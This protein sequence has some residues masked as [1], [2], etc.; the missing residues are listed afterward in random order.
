MTLPSLRF[1][2]AKRLRNALLIV[3]A[4]SLIS[5]ILLPVYTDE[6]GWRLQERA[7]LD[8]L[9][10]LYSDICGPNTLAVPPWFMW[11]VRYYSAF[12]N[13]SFPDP[14]FIRLSGIGYALVWAVLLLALTKA[15]AE[16]IER[17]LSLQMIAFGLMTMGVMP[18]LL[19]W[20]RPEQ[21]ILLCLTAAL[22]VQATAK[23]PSRDSLASASLRAAGILTLCIIALSYHLKAVVLA[24]IFVVCVLSV[25]SGR[26]TMLPRVIAATAALAAAAVSFRYWTERL[27]CPDD[28]ASAALFAENN[29]GFQGLTNG[30]FLN[31]AIMMVK[32]IDILQFALRI[33]PEVVPTSIWIPSMVVHQNESIAFALIHFLSWLIALGIFLFYLL[34]GL[35]Q[36]LQWRAEAVRFILAVMLVGA[37]LAW[38]APLLI[39]NPYEAIFVLPTIMLGMLFGFSRGSGPRLNSFLNAYARGIAVVGMVSC[40]ASWVFYGP[41]LAKSAEQSGYLQR[42]P[43]SVAPFNYSVTRDQIRSAAALCR[44]ENPREQTRILIDDVTYFSF[45]ESRMPDHQIGVIGSWK[46]GIDDPLAYL[47]SRNSSGIFVGCHLLPPDIRAKAKR[48]GAI[49]C[50]NLR[51]STN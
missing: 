28:P 16:K 20:S 3:F 46:G 27:K 1:F 48:H 49:C 50:L 13:T 5:G 40:L 10:K 47:R 44:M 32:N 42:Q 45:M 11:P 26:R 19:V 25:A 51:D 30:N 24:P 17:R 22:L 31:T 39:V 4:A 43:F 38:S 29:L 12:W 34:F 35:R 37:G 18:L 21:P 14:L 6:I 7:A 2:S 15:L 41:A 36:L 33:S 23:G 8:G 9:D